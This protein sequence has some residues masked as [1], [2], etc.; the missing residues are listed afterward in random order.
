MTAPQHALVTGEI[1]GRIPTPGDDF[2]HDFYDVTPPVLYF[3]DPQHVA[4][5][6]HAIEVE[7]VVR[8]THPLQLECDSLNDAAQHPNGVDKDRVKAHQ[9]AH[10]ALH[11]RVGV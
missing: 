9:A 2:P 1:S 4:A 3:D 11:A 8:R 10:K 5:L 6:A 7:H